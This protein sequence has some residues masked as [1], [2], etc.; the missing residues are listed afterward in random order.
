MKKQ[1]PE[2]SEEDLNYGLSKEQV[3]L[4]ANDLREFMEEIEHY[5]VEAPMD[6]Q[7][8]KDG[9]EELVISILTNPIKND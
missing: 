9:F 5:F 7:D 4:V 3:L 2:I 1:T 8:R 6:F